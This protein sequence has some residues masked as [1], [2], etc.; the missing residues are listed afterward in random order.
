MTEIDWLIAMWQPFLLSVLAGAMGVNAVPHF[1]K[2]VV[3]EPFP[4]VWG[5][6][7]L[8]NAVAGVLGLVIA[9]LLGYW[10]ELPGHFWAG[11]AGAGIGALAMAV[12]HGAGGAYRLNAALGL[13]NPPR[14][15]R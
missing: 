12:F 15:A 10:A 8:R 5:N 9:V 14:V 13:P 4:N 1:V 7:P 3:G 2:G 11:L 6:S